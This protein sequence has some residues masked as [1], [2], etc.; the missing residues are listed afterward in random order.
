M[1]F[2]HEIACLRP[3]NRIRFKCVLAGVL[4][5]ISVLF[6]EMLCYFY[7]KCNRPYTTL[8]CKFM[9]SWNDF[10]IKHK[11]TVKVA[12]IFSQQHIYIFFKVF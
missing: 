3:H 9:Q 7:T 12:N 8:F 10:G 11:K 2:K 4:H 6:F 5:I 1:I